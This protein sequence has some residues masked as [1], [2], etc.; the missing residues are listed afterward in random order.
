MNMVAEIIVAWV[1]EKLVPLH[2]IAVTK[3]DVVEIVYSSFNDIELLL[4]TPLY[5]EHSNLSKVT[6]GLLL[7]C[8][9]F[10][11]L[12]YWKITAMFASKISKIH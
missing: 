12:I 4:K 9:G 1:Q 8:I 6:I 10:K 3:E 11:H 2:V 7:V 5:G